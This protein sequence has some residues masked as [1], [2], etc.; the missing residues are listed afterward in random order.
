VDDR[1]LKIVKEAV[2]ELNEELD[3]ETLENCSEN[4]V[5]FG[6]EDGIDSLSLVRLVTAVETEVN[7]LFDSDILL[8]SEKAMSM[9]SSP[10]RSV[11]ALVQFIEEELKAQA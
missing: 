11:A 9:S 10:Y 5:L 2:A 8:A 6:G 3:Y 1:V 4:T 7:D